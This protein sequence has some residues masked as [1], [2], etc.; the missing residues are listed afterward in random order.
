[1]SHQFQDTLDD[2]LS[3]LLNDLQQMEGETHCKNQLLV[4]ATVPP[5]LDARQSHFLGAVRKPAA[6]CGVRKALRR[7]TKDDSDFQIDMLNAFLNHMD[8]SPAE[9]FVLNL[10]VGEQIGWL[11]LMRQQVPAEM[12]G[13]EP[14]RESLRLLSCS[15]SAIS[16]VF[17]GL[18]FRDILAAD[19]K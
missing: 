2:E 6:Q 16:Q 19:F 3:Q 7:R 14:D 1:M 17:Q 11:D 9:V 18:S 12:S 4:E 15:V 10:E 5:T 8:L 13:L